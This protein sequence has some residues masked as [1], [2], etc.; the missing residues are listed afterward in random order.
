MKEAIATQSCFRMLYHH[1][2]CWAL[3]YESYICVIIRYAHTKEKSVIF[4]GQ[5]SLKTNCIL[6][7]QKMITTTTL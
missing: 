4:A 6:S 3:R 5:V 2:F 1:H 7:H